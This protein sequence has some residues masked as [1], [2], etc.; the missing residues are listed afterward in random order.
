MIR[1]NSSNIIFDSQV[2]QS[3]FVEYLNNR[4]LRGS[5]VMTGTSAT[6]AI[7]MTFSAFKG[8]Y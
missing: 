7:S 4:G 2:V 6:V 5:F 1:L 3:T 8:I